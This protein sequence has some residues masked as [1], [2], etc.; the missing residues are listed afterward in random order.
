MKESLGTNIQ[1]TKYTN[2]NFISVK[3]VECDIYVVLQMSRIKNFLENVH[4]GQRY[5]DKRMP[6]TGM[7]D[8]PA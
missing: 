1:I 8:L 5:S 6:L 2:S 4:S 7:V 3:Q